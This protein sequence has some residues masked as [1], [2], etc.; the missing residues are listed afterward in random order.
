MECSCVTDDIIGNILLIKLSFL[1]L[2]LS[3][4]VV[5]DEIPTFLKIS[6]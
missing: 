3:L 4:E 5:Q 1:D 6:P 2:F